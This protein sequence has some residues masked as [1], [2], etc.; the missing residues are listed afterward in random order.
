[1]TETVSVN[2]DI[3]EKLWEQLKKK[4]PD[5]EDNEILEKIIGGRKIQTRKR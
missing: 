5:L 2:S 3:D 4:F 1:M